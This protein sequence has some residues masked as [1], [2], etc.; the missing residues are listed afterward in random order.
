MVNTSKK[1]I[2]DA[3]PSE[4]CN[5]SCLSFPPTG[6]RTIESGESNSLLLIGQRGSGKTTLINNILNKLNK[7]VDINQNAF[8]VKLHGLVHTDDRLAL[9]EITSQMNLENAVDG[10]VFGS[11]AEN[12]AFLLACLRMGQR[13]ISKGVIV[14]LEEFDLFCTHH[15]QTLLYNL[16]DI[17]Q[18]AQTPLC[19]VGITCRLDVI[20]LLEKRVKSRFSHRQVFLFPEDSSDLGDSDLDVYLDNIEYYLSFTNDFKCDLP[21]NYK[22]KWNNT[23]LTLTSDKKLK[24]LLQR[25]MDIDSNERILKNILMVV[26]STL[27]DENKTIKVENFEQEI[28]KLEENESLNILLDLSVLEMCLLIAIKHHCDIYD[29]EIMNFEM[30]FTRFTKFVNTNSNIQTV[31]R[32]VLMKAFEHLQN[33]ELILPI[34]QDGAK[35]QKE[36]RMFKLL[37]PP[38]LI[39]EAVSFG[40]TSIFGLH[41]LHTSRRHGRVPSCHAINIWVRNFEITRSALERKPLLQRTTENME[42]VRAFIARSPTQSPRKYPAALNLNRTS[43]HRIIRTF[44]LPCATF[45]ELMTEM[46]NDDP[47]FISNLII[48]DED[49]IYLNAEL[50]TRKKLLQYP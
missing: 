48:S 19:V 39:T 18:S 17:S 10:K 35:V 1:L 6:K 43:I 26:V 8:I 15:N 34:S 30:I 25:L 5:M 23:I 31:Q 49:H 27:N 24:T 42:V 14:I 29:N 2:G 16:F 47:N 11:F 36:Y 20:E 44:K 22:R 50:K 32:P 12:L 21:T 45:I 3:T 40:I 37:L 7:N 41:K 9:K 33:M 28:N 4:A 46:I 38:Q 13:E